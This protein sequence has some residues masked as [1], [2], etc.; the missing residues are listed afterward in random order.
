MQYHAIPWNTMQYNAIPCNTIQYHAS[1]IT[2]NGAYHSPVGSIRPFY[3]FFKP[4]NVCLKRYT[5]LKFLSVSIYVVQFRDP[6]YCN[7]Y[8][9]IY[10]YNDF[11]SHNVHLVSNKWVTQGLF[12]TRTL[13][14][15]YL[16]HLTCFPPT[17]VATKLRLDGWRVQDHF[18]ANELRSTHCT[19]E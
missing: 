10:L 11:S 1:L 16:Q 17:T 3:S 15:C 12:R 2:A 8:L 18:I 6:S 19:V 14:L 13:W 9:C 4:E 5:F 7:E